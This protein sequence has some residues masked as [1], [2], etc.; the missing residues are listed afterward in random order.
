[1]RRLGRCSVPLLIVAG[2]L[3]S[4]SPAPA[5]EV[6]YLTTAQVLPGRCDPS[7]LLAGQQTDCRFPLSETPP[8]DPWGGPH[9]PD[10]DVP[11]DDDDDQRAVCVVEGDGRSAEGSRPVTRPATRCWRWSAGRL[12]EPSV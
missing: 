12:S 8:P 6:S 7:P 5:L 10:A 2:L 1:M 4:A 9:V 3:L 11:W